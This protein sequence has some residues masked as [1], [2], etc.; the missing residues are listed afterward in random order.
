MEKKWYKVTFYAKMTEEDVKA[1]NGCF[2][3][4]MAQDMQIDEVDGLSIQEEDTSDL[5]GCGD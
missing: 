3:E 1:M 2:Y 5:C 4:T